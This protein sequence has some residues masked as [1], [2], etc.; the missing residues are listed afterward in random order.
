MLPII[1]NKK[2]YCSSVVWSC[3]Y[4]EYFRYL[5]TKKKKYRRF[6]TK[7]FQKYL[8]ENKHNF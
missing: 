6:N 4:P 2:K 5:G 8:W 7:L 3:N 1:G